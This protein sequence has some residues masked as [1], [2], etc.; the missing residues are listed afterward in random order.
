MC[1]EQGKNRQGKDGPGI[2]KDEASAGDCKPDKV[3][4]SVVE[5]SRNS[6]SS[7]WSGIN[8]KFICCS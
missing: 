4:G 6:N 3:S 1:D 5:H 7:S 2:L 8:S